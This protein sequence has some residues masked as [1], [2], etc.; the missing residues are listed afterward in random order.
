M[1]IRCLVYPKVDYRVALA[2]MSWQLN[3]WTSQ[4]LLLFQPFADAV[5]MRLSYATF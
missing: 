5:F 2:L 1:I 4:Q 3:S